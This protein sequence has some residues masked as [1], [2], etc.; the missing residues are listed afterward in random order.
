M[1]V[2]IYFK[3]NEYNIT[4]N[5]DDKVKMILKIKALSL[6]KICGNNII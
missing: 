2:M 6:Y 5:H 1:L 4:N 3:S